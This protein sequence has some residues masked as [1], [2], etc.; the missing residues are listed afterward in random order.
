MLITFGLI[1][2]CIVQKLPHLPIPR[3]I[4]GHFLACFPQ[5]TCVHALCLTRRTRK[6][7]PASACMGPVCNAKL[8]FLNFNTT[9]TV[10]VT[11]RIKIDLSIFQKLF[12]FS[13]FSA[14]IFLSIRCTPNMTHVRSDGFVIC[15]VNTCT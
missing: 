14:L 6:A 9:F 13:T 7:L 10:N 5:I 2:N 15:V 3:I 11:W 8:L 1:P 12:A 4:N